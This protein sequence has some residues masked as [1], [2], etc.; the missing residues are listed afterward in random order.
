MRLNNK[1]FAPEKDRRYLALG[2]LLPTT[3]MIVVE[4]DAQWKI[5]ERKE[6]QSLSNHS[7]LDFEEE[8]ETSEPSWWISLL[9]LIMFLYIEDARKRKTA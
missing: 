5:L 3:S 6:K 1:I 8:Q 7:A 9:F 4:R 2:L